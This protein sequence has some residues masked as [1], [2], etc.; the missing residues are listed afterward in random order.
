MWDHARGKPV[1]TTDRGPDL[2]EV[3]QSAKGQDLCGR[4]PPK[5]RLGRTRPGRSVFLCDES[6]GA[7]WTLPDTARLYMYHCGLTYVL[8]LTYYITVCI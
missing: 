7:R 5:L 2:E 4:H 3:L 8:H 1:P 6:A